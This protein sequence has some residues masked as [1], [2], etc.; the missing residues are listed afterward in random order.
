M[1][2]QVGRP[3]TED[4]D[5][6][7]LFCGLIYGHQGPSRRILQLQISADSDHFG[8]EDLIFH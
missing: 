5:F 6:R 7:L 8:E 1:K 4:I 2:F 3:R